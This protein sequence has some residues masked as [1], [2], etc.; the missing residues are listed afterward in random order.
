MELSAVA[1]IASAFILIITDMEL[2]E[3][4]PILVGGGQFTE[5][6]VAPERALSPMGIAAAA[7]R[8]ALSDTGIGDKL[9]ALIDTLMVI[10]IIFDSTNRPRLPS[11]SQSLDAA[12][13]DGWRKNA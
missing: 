13:L 4:T 1:L 2:E 5:K 9:T 7:A 6:D 12:L 10:R 11:G 8:A 3:S